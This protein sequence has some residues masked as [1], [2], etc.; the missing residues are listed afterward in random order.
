MA[1]RGG[2]CHHFPPGT[3]VWEDT[4]GC[5]F[6]RRRPVLKDPFVTVGAC[7]YLKW[8]AQGRVR[9]AAGVM[10]LVAGRCLDLPRGGRLFRLGPAGLSGL[11]LG[12]GDALDGDLEQVGDGAGEGQFG[13]DGGQAAAGEAA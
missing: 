7:W 1:P 9:R 4:T 10:R 12:G 11:E 6:I 5:W 2:A 8:V 13:L 3:G